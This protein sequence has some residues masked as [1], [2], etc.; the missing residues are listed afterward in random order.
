MPKLTKAQRRLRD[1]IDLAYLARKFRLV[2][3]RG[4]FDAAGRWWDDEREG[5]NHPTVREP[6]R[7]WPYSYLIACRTRKWC[8]QLP[9]KTRKE[10]AEVARRAIECHVL[11]RDEQGRWTTE[12]ALEVENGG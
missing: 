5:P 1:E 6:S 2:N 4:K 12:N 7:K 11:L 10:D 8:A 3:P 9:V